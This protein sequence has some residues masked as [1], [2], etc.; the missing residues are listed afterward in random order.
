MF[1]WKYRVGDYMSNEFVNGKWTDLRVA[2]TARAG[3][4]APTLSNFNSTGIYAYKF[5]SNTHELHFSAQM[6][7]GWNKNTLLHPHIHWTHDST[8]TSGQVTWT[9]EYVTNKPGNGDPWSA[10]QTLTANGP[11]SGTAYHNIATD[12]STIDVSNIGGVDYRSI[13]TLF[14]FRLVRSGNTTNA[15]D[16]FLVEFDLHYAIDKHGTVGINTEP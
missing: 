6:P 3:A 8:W 5:T 10:K 13:S 4:S 11:T 16:P 9:L 15:G 2:T 14:L 12:F 7:H 1:R